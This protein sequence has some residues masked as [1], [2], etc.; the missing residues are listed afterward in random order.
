L[1]K[2]LKL[3]TYISHTNFKHQL[4]EQFTDH[5]TCTVH[6]PSVNNP[7]NYL[8]PILFCFFAPLHP[9]ISTCTCIFSTSITPVFNC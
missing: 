1:Q 2:S 3:E 9:R 4:S 7:P 6:S 5:C 8:I